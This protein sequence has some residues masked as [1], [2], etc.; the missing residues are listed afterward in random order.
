[1]APGVADAV[2]YNW[3]PADLLSNPH[4]L[5]PVA[6]VFR[7][8]KFTLTAT[9]S[10]GCKSSDHMMISAF[11][12]IYIPSAF[13]PNGDGL[14]DYWQISGLSEQVHSTV[15]IYD[16]FG[17]IIYQSSGKKHQWDGTKGGQKMPSGNYV[18]M[19]QPGDGT[20]MRKGTITLLR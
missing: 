13:S 16:R 14:N 19:F 12:N 4:E 17:Q 7:D 2:S 10:F 11:E 18:Y 6:T 3:M 5:N 8:T 1:M 15:F 20:E 9:N